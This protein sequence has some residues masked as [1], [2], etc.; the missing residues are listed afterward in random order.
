MAEEHLR[1]RQ[2]VLPGLL[3]AQGGAV[4]HEH[5]DYYL[6]EFTFRFNRAAPRLA[7]YSSIG[8]F[9]K[10]WK[11]IPHRTDISSEA[12]VHRFHNQ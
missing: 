7:A 11:E 8:S 9:S 3:P 5:L 1:A 4:S 10:R 12:S 2:V 6:D